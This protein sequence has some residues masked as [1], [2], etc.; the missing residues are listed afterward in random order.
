M[1]N[2]SLMK[3]DNYCNCDEYCNYGCRVIGKRV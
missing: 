2:Q 3:T 1:Q